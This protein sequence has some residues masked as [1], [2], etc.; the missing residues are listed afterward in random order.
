MPKHLCRTIICAAEYA[1][2]EHQTINL[3]ETMKLKM[4][5]KEKPYIVGH[6]G[7]AGGWL[8]NFL[9]AVVVAF[10]AP[11]ALAAISNVDIEGAAFNPD[12]VTINVNDQVVW[13]WVS[14]FHNT[15][16]STG[17]WDSGVFNAPHAF[18]NTFTS[19]GTFPYF[20]VVHGFTGTVNVQA[21]AAS[22]PTVAIISPT[23][24]AS[25][26]ATAIIPI[27][28]TASDSDGSVTNV[29]FFDGVTF[30][31]A[32]NNPSYTVTAN[33]ASGVHALTAVATDNQGLATTSTVV[34]VTVSVANLPPSVSITNPVENAVLSGSVA[35]TI[36]AAA[37][38]TDGSV[39]NVRFFDGSISL[40]ND[41]TS[42]YSITAS[43]ALGAH[44]L[45]A[46]A[47]DNL[48]ITAT[49]A[50]VHITMAGYLPPITN[51]NIVILLQP[52]A[53][54]LAAPDY[55][56]SPPGDTHRLFVVEQNGLLRI[57][58]DGI[59]LA[60]SAL[61]IQSR[62]TPPLV[63]TNPNDE[64]GFLGLAFH[65]GFS[66]PASPGYRT[67]YTYNSEVIGTTPTY[68]APNG[69][70]QNYKNVVNEWKISN[71]N[72]NV[73]DPASRREIISFGKNA[74]NH[75]GGTLAF[76]PD[77]YLYLALG[78][79]G[80][81]ND[82]GASHIEPGGNAQNL[83]TPLGKFLRFDP[84]NPAVNPASPDLVSANGQYRIPTTNPFQGAG[85]VKEIYAYG[86]RNPYRFSFD[87]ANGELIHADVGQNNVEEIDRIVIG[88][89][90]GWAIKEGDFLF[91]RTNGP[92]GA[93][94][95]IGTPPGNRSPGFPAGLIDPI[96]GTQGTLEYDHND[97]I[98]ITGGFVYRGTAFTE[99]YGKYIFGDLAL[100]TAPVR[101]D[102]RI[103]YADLQTGL[104]KAFPLFQFGGS[105]ILPNGLTVHGFGQD[106]DGEIYALVTNTSANGTGGI[107]YKLVP[108]RLAVQRNGNQLD[109]SW[110]VTSGHLETQ[111]NS[112]IVGL[113]TSWITVP[114]SAATNH[115]VV[116]LDQSNGS[117]FYR[118]VLP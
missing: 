62:V 5:T 36:R 88:G 81:A 72:T 83:S 52:I 30:L 111:T 73:V 4:F 38:D 33:L 74:G 12:T 105:A 92:A 53:T 13:T 94:G 40:G 84:L 46:V 104:I 16:S 82:V 67:L 65:P 112:L 27:T 15:E 91:N 71:A 42:P 14:N 50:P 77:G 97:G 79:G 99:L 101:A 3:F 47:A 56:I 25:F 48:G 22:S 39:T 44:T 103:F 85:Q 49:S 106:A 55:A 66:I 34:N 100:K 21:A 45:T 29:S 108:L 35:V 68:P 10:V 116:P 89:N 75:N 87:R 64:R 54:N 95:T 102:G 117:V 107:V 57:I 69:A 8:K 86:L 32:T 61:D 9:F 24:G 7:R 63:P 80:D 1:I 58:Q 51:G 19:A 26:T 78:D 60:G 23:N 118:L 6:C 31:G 90:Y 114:G 110:P 41:A 2:S 109:I 96:T 43:L 37:A 28:A 113:G 17:L 11:S 59:L 20:C 93:A 115:V 98:S 18:T 76:G 70:A